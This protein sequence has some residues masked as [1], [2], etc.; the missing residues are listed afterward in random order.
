LGDGGLGEVM[1]RPGRRELVLGV[2]PGTGEGLGGGPD[3]GL[4]MGPARRDIVAD[5]AAVTRVDCLF[6]RCGG[7]NDGDSGGRV[8]SR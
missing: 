5:R 7:A 2:A 4:D 1:S 8:S 6:T 3:M